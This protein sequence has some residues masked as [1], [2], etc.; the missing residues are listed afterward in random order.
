LSILPGAFIFFS[1]ARRRPRLFILRSP[2]E[3]QI[4]SSASILPPKPISHK[5]IVALAPHLANRSELS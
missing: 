5:Q 4:E 2:K 1:N 3:I